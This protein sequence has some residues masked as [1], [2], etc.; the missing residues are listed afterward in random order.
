MRSY[1]AGSDPS[2]QNVER[3]W[4]GTG[5]SMAW[6]V[7]GTGPMYSKAEGE[8][9]GGEEKFVYRFSRR[10]TDKSTGAEGREVLESD[11]GREF[12][13]LPRYDVRVSAGG[14]AV[15][16]SEQIVDY[17]AFNRRWFEERVGI[18]PSQVVLFEIHGDSMM[19]DLEDGELVL[20]DTSKTAFAGEAIY[21]I[22]VGGELRIKWVKQ[23]IDGHVEIR[24]S[25]ERYGTE[26]LTA[27]QA[28]QLVIVGRARRALS[29]R[30]LP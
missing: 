21:V 25:N 20:I 6:L 1:L 29:D 2:R 13:L 10:S 5:C 19:P 11:D 23:R 4:R 22:L 17:Y 16:H 18:S 28:E 26:V 3:I 15:I 14:G 9:L 30:R 27:E 24:S 7:A 12:I 8:Q